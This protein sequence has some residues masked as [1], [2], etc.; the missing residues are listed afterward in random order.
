MTPEVFISYSR[1]NSEEIFPIVDRL[2]SFGL[3]IWIDQEGIHGAKLW[4]QEIVN[5]IEDSK[6]FIL[7]ASVT[8]F[9][10]KNV[11]KE[12]ALASESDKHILPVFLEDAKI[13]AAMKYQLAGIQHLVHK[14]G[15]PEA[16]VQNILKTLGTLDVEL[17]SDVQPTTE[18]PSVNLSR[19]AQKNGTSVKTV[20]VCIAAVIIAL[21]LLI[22]SF[23]KNTDADSERGSAKSKSTVHLGVTTYFSGDVANT[24]SNDNRELRDKLVSKLSR[25]C[26]YEVI[27]T[28]PVSIDV[29]TKTI[30]ST[31]QKIDVD[32]LIV[33]DF[34]ATEQEV[35]AKTYDRSGKIISV[36]EIDKSALTTDSDSLAEESTSI[37]SARLAGYDAAIH[38]DIL[39]KSSGKKENELNA[40]ELLARAKNVWNSAATNKAEI[41][42]R[43]LDKCIEVNPKISSAHSVRGQI[44]ANFYQSGDSSTN[45]LAIAKQ[46]NTKASRIDPNNAL[47]ILSKL[48][49]SFHEKDHIASEQLAKQ[50]LE[51]NPNEPFLL[52]TI[53]ASLILNKR[54]LEQGKEYIDKAI[55]YN[56]NPQDWY[57][58]VLESYHTQ[59]ADYRAALNTSLRMKSVKSVSGVRGPSTPIY[60]WLLGEKQIA[61]DKFKV[62]MKQMPPG[63]FEKKREE[64]KKD[65]K[66][67]SPVEQEMNTALN[68]LF[69]AYKASLEESDGE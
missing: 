14:P 36:I 17:D 37:I 19:D 10:S 59:H 65:L 4:S 35:N 32:Y 41:S 44:Y 20:G 9:E 62:L 13:P 8:A 39:L 68:E 51:A 66:D 3:N 49:V 47:V 57:Y 22:P 28:S 52:A 63:V 38:S 31:I 46:S 40:I 53:A 27:H 48:W 64:L 11:T 29:D 6:V 2:R 43:L 7:F 30:Q 5:A 55:A 61:L 1:D 54:E 56:S 23:L 15:D 21:A 12:L 25:F 60:Y 42:I 26:D 45:G 16:T 24:I 18:R 58:M 69:E 67:G 33:S 50:G 34:N